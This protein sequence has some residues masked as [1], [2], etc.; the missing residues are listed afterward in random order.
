MHYI[1]R[2]AESIQKGTIPFQFHTGMALKEGSH[3]RNLENLIKTYPN[4]RFHLLHCGYPWLMDTIKILEIYDN[5]IGEMVWLP[6][7]SIKELNNFL[8]EIIKRKLTRK[9]NAFGGDSGCVE[10]SI[11]ALCVLKEE[12]T[13]VLSEF[14]VTFSLSLIFSPNTNL[15]SFAI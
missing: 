6:Q 4:I 8:K 14:I 11:G 1:L 15:P 7:L 3:P 5:V 12:L 9:V 2:N 10:G 13:A